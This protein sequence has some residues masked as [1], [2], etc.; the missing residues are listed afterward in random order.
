MQ[1]QKQVQVQLQESSCGRRRKSAE[2]GRRMALEV[3][4]GSWFVGGRG[5]GGRRGGSR[6]GG[7]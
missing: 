5:G 3:A 7:G 2:V 4:G 6:V 1:E